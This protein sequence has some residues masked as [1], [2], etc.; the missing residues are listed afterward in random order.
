MS[1]EANGKKI[2]RKIKHKFKSSILNPGRFAYKNGH[3]KIVQF[4]TEI[5]QTEELSKAFIN[6][7]NAENV[8][9]ADIMDKEVNEFFLS[10]CSPVDKILDIGCGHGI[11][12]EFLAKKGLT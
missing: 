12:S 6:G 11:V 1:L 4:K 7:S 3:K 5:W 8:V 10:R 2:Y 9:A